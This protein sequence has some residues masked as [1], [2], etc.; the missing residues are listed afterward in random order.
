MLTRTD[1]YNDSPVILQP[2]SLTNHMHL[3]LNRYLLAYRKDEVIIMI[4]LITYF[5]LLLQFIL[6]P[7]RTFYFVTHTLLLVA[8]PT[9]GF[10]C[11]VF[12]VSVE[13]K[14]KLL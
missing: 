2:D 9:P 1:Y 10:P 7:R 4:G 3:L 11:G 12:H 14:G 8:Y 5:C 13:L 6:F